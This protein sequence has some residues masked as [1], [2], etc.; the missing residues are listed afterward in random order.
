MLITICSTIKFWPKILEIKKQLE[1]MGHEVLIPP[2]E[3]KNEKGDLIPVEQYY[4]I[5]K[6]MM[7][8]NGQEHDWIWQRKKEAMNSHFEKVNEAHVILVLNYEK[9]G[10]DNYIGGNV[11]LEI[12]LAFWLNKPIYFM[13]PIPQTLSY[14][15]E[16]K[17]MQPIIIN[18]DLTLIK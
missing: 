9:N 8:Q 4:E 3:V 16:L 18:G 10:V 7:A 15:E 5:R 11:L 13:N 6:Q 2:H 17:G 14:T 12:G 1:D